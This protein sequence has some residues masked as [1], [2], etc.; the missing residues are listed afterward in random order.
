MNVSARLIEVKAFSPAETRRL[1]TEPVKYSTLW[2]KDSARRPRF[3][4]AFWGEAG[5]D[6]IHA[7][8]GGWPFLVQL[9]AETTVDL[10][11]DEGLREVRGDVL[12]RAYE[13]AIERGHAGLYELVCRE[14]F[15]PGEWD[16]MER[17]RERESQPPPEDAKIARSLK[18]RLL[19]ENDG[20]E[21]RMRVP[22]MRR[23]LR[24]RG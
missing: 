24:E 17:F 15:L 8:T 22:L 2:E 12:E 23:W 7:E 20:A 6:R 13:R 16:Y 1:L 3:D 11:N 10:L 5:I 18:R 4:E 9:V 21:W 14:C 19:V